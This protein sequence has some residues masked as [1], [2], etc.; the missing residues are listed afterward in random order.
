MF[1]VTDYAALTKHF[2]AFF[3]TS[4]INSIIHKH[5]IFRFYIS[6]DTKNTLKL[7]FGVKESYGFDFITLPF[8]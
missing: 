5:K 8:I 3:A 6:Y 7:C 2:I 1:K 4:L